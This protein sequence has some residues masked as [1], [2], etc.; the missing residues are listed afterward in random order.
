MLSDCGPQRRWHLLTGNR[1]AERHA[2]VS[3]V[4]TTVGRRRE[5]YLDSHV[6]NINVLRRRGR[7]N[8]R[9]DPARSNHA[10]SVR[11]QVARVEPTSARL[12]GKGAPN[13]V[14]ATVLPNLAF[15]TRSSTC[16]LEVFVQ[17]V[18]CL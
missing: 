1:N 9:I 6:I 4:V 10:V 12:I 7:R 14:R 16:V 8:L 3:W 18:C 13:L 5:R 15:T 2:F 17:A 11:V